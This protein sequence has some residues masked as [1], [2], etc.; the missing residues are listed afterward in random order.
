MD[1][2]VCTKQIKQFSYIA[3]AVIRVGDESFEVM[4]DNK[5]NLFWINKQK[6]RNVDKGI[7]GVISGHSISYK[8]LNSKQYEFVV[9]LGGPS[10]LMKTFKKFVF[11]SIRDATELTFGSSQGLFGVFGTGEV[12]FKG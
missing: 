12:S 9:D 10:I 2:H 7:I 4:G 5:E 3:S 6:G 8:Q 11:V 1:I